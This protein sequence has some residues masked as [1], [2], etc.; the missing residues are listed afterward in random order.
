M[1]LFAYSR[2]HIHVLCALVQVN[3]TL[4]KELLQVKHTVAFNDL[5]FLGIDMP[6]QTKSQFGTQ[7]RW[8]F[9]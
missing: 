6:M 3:A 1:C 5:V 9:T 8:L 2:D 4:N 7:I